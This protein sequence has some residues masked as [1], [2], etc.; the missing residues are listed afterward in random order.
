MLRFLWRTDVHCRDVGPESRT[1]DWA[2]AVMAKLK[3]VGEVARK[4]ECDAVIDGGDFFDDKT[5]IRT[6]HRLV[7][8]VA[9]VHSDYGIP[10]YANV[11]NHDVRLAQINNL[12]ENPLEVLFATGVF[13]RLYDDHELVM[14]KDGVKVRVVGIPYH[15]PRYDLDRFRAVRRRDEDYL[16]CVAHVL[17]SRQGG[18]MFANEDI[19]K[20]SDLP[21]LNPDVDCWNFG[22]WHKNQGI[23]EIAP[24]KWVVN[25]G[26]L[27]RG[28]LTQDNVEREPGVVVMGFWPREHKM[29]PALEFVKIRVAPAKEVFDM[30]K[31]VREET[32]SMTVDAFVESVKEELQTCSDKPFLEIV[33]GM[34]LPARVR[35]R[36]LEYIAA[37]ER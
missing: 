20:Y 2:D 15:G 11:G 37:A 14:E 21:Q 19:I 12:H 9:Q 17:A 33:E 13:R 24:G 32:R 34:D 27:T 6:T 22:H 30:E 5:P 18:E 1:D 28:A 29:P 23:E 7:S 16:V 36:A 8:R 26:S 31:R 35:E 4:H 25:T 10:V 3:Q